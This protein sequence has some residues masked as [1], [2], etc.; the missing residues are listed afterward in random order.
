MSRRA[1]G[2]PRHIRGLFL[3]LAPCLRTARG[4][5]YPA[6]SPALAPSA[7]ACPGSPPRRRPLLARVLRFIATRAPLPSSP[8]R[9]VMAT[10][11]EADEKRHAGTT[12][13]SS[14]FRVAGVASR[15]EPP[16]LQTPQGADSSP[17]WCRRAFR[18]AGRTPA[19][20]VHAQPTLQHVY[21][22]LLYVREVNVSGRAWLAWAWPCRPAKERATEPGAREGGAKGARAG[23]VVV[24]Q[25]RSCGPG[26][27]SAPL[28]KTCRRP[29]A[30]AQG[31]PPDHPP[32]ASLSW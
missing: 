20:H 22:L 23:C 19:P 9:R 7:E 25:L 29:V 31:T 1:P 14:V 24:V 32:M 16:P 4:L 3:R 11:G 27:E 5:I 12:L 10:H 15:E 2:F 8:A 21:G 30:E 28:V 13:A 26:L 17:R 6:Q 18:T